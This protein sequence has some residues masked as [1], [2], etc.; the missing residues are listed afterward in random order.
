VALDVGADAIAL[1]ITTRRENVRTEIDA[2]RASVGPDLPIV[3]GGQ[4]AQAGADTDHRTTV[5][6]GIDAFRALLHARAL[7]R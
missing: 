1:S 2:L 6:S 7:A 5:V 4:H 3:V